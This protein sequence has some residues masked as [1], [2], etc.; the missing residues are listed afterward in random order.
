MRD[1]QVER[2]IHELRGELL[3]VW[4]GWCEAPAYDVLQDGRRALRLAPDGFDVCAFLDEEIKRLASVG[5]P[6]TFRMIG[7]LATLRLAEPRNCS[8]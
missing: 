3:E 7:W 1:F 4:H 8:I 6:K 5:G 2:D